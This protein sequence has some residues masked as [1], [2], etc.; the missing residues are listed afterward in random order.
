[1]PR[2]PLRTAHPGRAALA[3]A[4]AGVLILTGSLV[5]FMPYLT[6][7]QQ[8]VAGVPDPAALLAVSEFA[9]PAHQQACMSAVTVEPDS[10]LAAFQLRPAKATP[11]GGPP[12]E[13]VLSAPGYRGVVEV[14]GGYPGGGVELPLSPAPRSAVIAEACFLNRGSTVVLLDGTTETRTVSRSATLVNGRPVPG[15]IAL[16]LLQGSPQSLLDRIG[17][18]FGHASNLTDRLIPV[19]LIWVLALLVAFGVPISMLGAFYLALQ[20][21]EL[22]SAG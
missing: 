14:P 3:T 2:G 12:V 10:R 20:E 1:M 8:P 5:W 18:A 22:T 11:G 6:R 7:K 13:L 21:D 17:E 19:W 9:V 4:L 16:T 15:D